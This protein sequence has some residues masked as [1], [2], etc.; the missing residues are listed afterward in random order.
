MEAATSNQQG[1]RRP[2]LSGVDVHFGREA[3]GGTGK[4]FAFEVDENSLWVWFFG[5]ELVVSRRTGGEQTAG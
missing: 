2:L 1:K 4:R 3:P 5:R